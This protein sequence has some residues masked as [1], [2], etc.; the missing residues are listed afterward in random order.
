MKL[1]VVKASDGL[2]CILC[3]LHVYE[4]IIFHDVTFDDWTVLLKFG[5]KLLV[6][7]SRTDSAHMRLGLSF[8][9]ILACFHVDVHP[10]QLV[11]VQVANGILGRRLVLYVYKAVVLNDVTFQ[12]LP[13]L[14]EQ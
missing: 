3:P 9:L 11:V 2:H 12:H 4:G 13:I 5:P 7:T 6:G 1:C 10:V 14:L 8:A